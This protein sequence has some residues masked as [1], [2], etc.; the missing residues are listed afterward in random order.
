VKCNSGNPLTRPTPVRGTPRY[1]GPR[2]PGFTPTS[3]VVI[4][5]VA[6]RIDVYV[7]VD[8]DT[9][10]TFDRPAGT[11]GDRDGPLVPPDGE[12]PDTRPPTITEPPAVTEPPTTTEPPGSA[13]DF[14]TAMREL[15][16]YIDAN[17]ARE[18]P[19]VIA[20]LLDRFAEATAVAPP[21]L[22]ADM[23]LLNG[24]VQAAG[25]SGFT[26]PPDDPAY[27]AAGDRVAAWVSA[28]CGFPLDDG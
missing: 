11:T 3:V 28:T 17:F 27:D 25:A 24:A 1:T 21:E 6:V 13:A 4:S 15:R 9:G 20:G 8:L 7:L 5:E 26:D 16:D 14:C 2:W 10:G 12:P 19:A 22:R 18:D 23:E